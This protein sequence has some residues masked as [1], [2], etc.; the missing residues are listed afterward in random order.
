[1]QYPRKYF[2][3]FYNC[4]RLR[5]TCRKKVNK[6]GVKELVLN[7]NYFIE[8]ISSSMKGSLVALIFVDEYYNNRMTLPFFKNTT[9]SYINLEETTH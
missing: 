5:E 3:S 9:S 2:S 1:M 4:N 7:K 6:K 8:S